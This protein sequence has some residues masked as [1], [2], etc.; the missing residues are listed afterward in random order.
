VWRQPVRS[1]RRAGYKPDIRGLD[2]IEKEG[3]TMKLRMGVWVL[4]CTLLASCL[5]LLAQKSSEAQATGGQA[6]AS[7]ATDPEKMNIEAYIVL[8]REDVWDEK[9][10]LLGSVMQLDADDAAKFWPIFDEYNSELRKLHDSM[11]ANLKTYASEY[12]QLTDDKANRVIKGA[13]DHRKQQLELLDRYYERV[14][15]ALGAVTASRFVE[16]EHQLLLLIDLQLLS[17]L[18]TTGQGQ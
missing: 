3:E 15:Q 17:S 14:K 18:P 1:Y 13:I 5:V 7:M 9:G 8:L 2:F 10:Q 4:L 6:A 11:R 16:V 12:S